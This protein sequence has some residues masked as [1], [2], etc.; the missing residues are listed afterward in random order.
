MISRRSK[1][2]NIGMVVSILL[3]GGQAVLADGEVSFMAKVKQVQENALV[4]E[5]TDSLHS[6]KVKIG[7]DLTILIQPWM[8]F[9]DHQ[10]RLIQKPK[11]NP[12]DHLEIKPLTFSGKEVVASYIRIVRR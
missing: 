7:E 4:V 2:L 11:L 12:G 8:P 1:L 3:L 5:V 6:V 10:D 9:R